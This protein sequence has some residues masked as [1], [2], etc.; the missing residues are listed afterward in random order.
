MRIDVLNCLM[1]LF[2]ILTTYFWAVRNNKVTD[3]DRI[4]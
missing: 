2:T 4:L 3:E 1:G